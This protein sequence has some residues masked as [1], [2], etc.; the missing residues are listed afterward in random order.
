[1]KAGEK[2][3]RKLSGGRVEVLPYSCRPDSGESELSVATKGRRRAC[4]D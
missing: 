2:F 1:M 4:E 3:E